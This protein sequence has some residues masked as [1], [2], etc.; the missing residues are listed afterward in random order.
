MV[1][2][3]DFAELRA[4]VEGL[5]LS[6]FVTTQLVDWVYG[7]GVTDWDRMT[8]LSR[9]NREL[10]AKELPFTLT[11][12]K[13]QAEGEVVKYLWRLA[14]GKAVESVLILAE[15]RRTVCVS[16]QVGCAARCAFCA[17]GQNG[18]IRDLSCGEIVE[19]VVR[20]NGV[21]MEKGERVS[22]VVFMGMGEPLHNRSAVFPALRHL[23]DAQLLGISRRR[24]TVSTVGVVEGIHELAQ[25]GLDVNLALSLHAPTQEL[26]RRLI[27]YAREV[28]LGSLLEAVA[29]YAATTG[30]NATYE[31][32]LIAGVNDQPEHAEGLADL[33]DN[34][35]CTVN[36]IPYNPV[37]G[38]RL[39]RPSRESVSAFMR[40]LRRRNVVATCRI[41][42]G[43]DI[44]AACG[45]LALQE[46]QAIVGN[47]P[48]QLQ[49]I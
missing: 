10:L 17:S 7:K 43:D 38:R 32:T 1:C 46:P 31:Y 30:R 15:G 8:N 19:Q 14:D 3:L 28:D 22:H 45:Q 33:L 42:K 9:A 16:S 26:R 40:T 29:L 36:C 35:Q 49:L 11:L 37:P 27:P 12:D 13:S 5:G 20:I 24:I 44:A 23:T 18:L 47:S 25:S 2:S 34:Q 4:R 48:Q 6:R 39:E 41:T 21:L